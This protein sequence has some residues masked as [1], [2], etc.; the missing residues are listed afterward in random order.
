MFNRELVHL[1]C[2][3]QR[4]SLLRKEQRAAAG[5]EPVGPES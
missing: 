5:D 2:H 1:Y 4:H 3:Q